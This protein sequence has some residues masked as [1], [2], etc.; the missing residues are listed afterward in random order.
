MIEMHF[1]LKG[2]GIIVN[3]FVHSFL[4]AASTVYGMPRQSVYINSVPGFN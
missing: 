2:Y 1:E 4:Y 3:G